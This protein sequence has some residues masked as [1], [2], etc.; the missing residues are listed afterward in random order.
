MKDWKPTTEE[1]EKSLMT[2]YNDDFYH[3]YRDEATTLQYLYQ[4]YRG[5]HHQNQVHV[6]VAVLDDFFGYHLSHSY[7]LSQHIV[8]MN[9][10]ERL[11]QGDVCVVNDICNVLYPVDKEE[12]NRLYSFATRYCNQH[13]AQRFPIYDSYSET[14]MAEYLIEDLHGQREGTSI[15]PEDM[16]DYAVFC[17]VVK[18]FLEHYNLKCGFRGLSHYF[19]VRCEE[20]KRKQ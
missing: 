3:K 11:K 18:L 4:T 19:F 1:V 14:C 16:K 10:D 9:I 6:K 15:K 13:E 8:S 5:N 12:R 17:H 2:Y 20:K 7:Q